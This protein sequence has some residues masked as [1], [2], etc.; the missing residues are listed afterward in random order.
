MAGYQQAVSMPSD[1]HITKHAF[2][3]IIVRPNNLFL[4]VLPLIRLITYPH[5]LNK[6]RLLPQHLI[7]KTVNGVHRFTSSK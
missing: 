3:L 5:F 7:F 1:S 6:N 4:S 2:S